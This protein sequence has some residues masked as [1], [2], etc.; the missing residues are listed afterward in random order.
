MTRLDSNFS[1][2]GTEC[3]GWLFLPDGGPDEQHGR[4]WP[5]VVMAHGFSGERAMFLPEY[6][7]RFGQAGMAAFVFDYRGF[8]DSRGQPRNV[9]SPKRHLAD[10][11]AALEHV[12]G[13]DRIDGHRIGLWGTSY[14]GGHVLVTAARDG[15]VKAV[16]AQVP[17]V[18]GR[19][20]LTYLP[21]GLVLA[22]LW[23]GLRD[24]GRMITF[25]KPHYVPVAG[26]PGKFAVLNGPDAEPGI[27]VLLPPGYDFPNRCAARALVTMSLYRP[28]KFAPKI[29]CP[30]M[31]VMA[32]DDLYIP[33]K[34]VARAAGR[35]PRAELVRRPGGHFDV[36][37]GND[38]D[39]VAA[40]E[41]EFL[42]RHLGQSGLAE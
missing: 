40:L 34:A 15:G 19:T 2:Q 9:V 10:W 14:S 16:V 18:D 4:K 6:A 27:Q 37:Q 38:F 30:V 1:S 5:V 42:A 20:V 17:F 36:Y 13:L 28:I 25:R 7:A 24:L 33:A 26:P 32:E 41:A 11:D 23:H 12:R 8:G 3:A 39:Q 21:M 29:N 31:M 35:I 22:G